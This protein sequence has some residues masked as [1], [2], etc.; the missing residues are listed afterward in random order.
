MDLEYFKKFINKRCPNAIPLFVVLRGSHAYGTNVESSDEDY[1]GVYI[2][3]MNDILGNNYKEQIND[4]KNDTVFYE[5]KRFVE[6]LSTANPTMIELLNTPEDCIIYKHPSFDSIIKEKDKFITRKCKHSFGGY[7]KQ[8]ISKASGQDKKVNWEKDKVSRKNTIDFVYFFEEGK[9]IQLS[10]Y[11][12][13]T[14]LDQRFCG[15]SSLP[16]ARDIYSLYYDFNSAALYSEK[17]TKN[18]RIISKFL[19]KL[20]NLIALSGFKLSPGN[21]Y[22]GIAFEK[23]NSIRLSSIPKYAD[24]F[25]GYITYNKDAYSQ[26][27]DD[28]RS[29]QTWLKNKNEARWVDVEAHG[30]KIDGKNM[31]HCQRLLNMAKEIAEGKGVIVRRPDAEYLKSI[32]KGQIDLQTLIDAAE[33]TIKEIDYIFDNNK[34]LPEE[35]PQELVSELILGIRKSIYENKE[36]LV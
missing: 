9:T 16:H 12:E 34:T 17:L 19:F 8:Q 14:G 36:L 22:N 1:A 2:Q 33:A 7:A 24:G 10:E 13:K 6:L 15:L 32:R 28:Y 18:S 29:Y 21:G 26:H 25:I 31:L 35:V 20:S 3:D 4:D 5:V 30:Q 23:S 11:L 27:C